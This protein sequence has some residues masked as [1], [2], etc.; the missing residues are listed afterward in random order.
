MSFWFGGGVPEISVTDLEEVRGREAPVQLVDVREP[1]EFGAG[2]VAGAVLVPLG[3]LHLRLH[4]LDRDRP[5]YVICQTGSRSAVA[6]RMLVQA[7][8]RDVRNVAGGTLAWWTSGR[9][10][11]RGH[12]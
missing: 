4:E 12:E 11:A 7:G 10:L 2:H 3:S 6:T 5:T 1:D 9:P 8:F